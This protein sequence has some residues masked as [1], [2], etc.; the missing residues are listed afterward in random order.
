AFDHKASIA[1]FEEARRI[2]PSCAMCAWGEAWS[3]GPTLN[4]GVSEQE[5]AA[6]SKTAAEAQRLS[7]GSSAIERA[8]IAA[9]VTRYAGGKVDHAG[10]AAAMDA[11]ANAN[12]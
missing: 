10:Y 7:E 5:A 12:P 9:M 4:Y 1:A 3:K 8:L 6:L 2:D 11:I